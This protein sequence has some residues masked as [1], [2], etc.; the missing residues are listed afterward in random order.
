VKRG[1]RECGEEDKLICKRRRKKTYKRKR[2]L[3]YLETVQ[4][5]MRQRGGSSLS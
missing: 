2:R 3:K 1:L 5:I 4:N